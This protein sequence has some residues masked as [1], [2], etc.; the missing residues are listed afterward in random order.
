MY[1]CK[2]WKYDGRGGVVVEDEEMRVEV[3]IY[4]L[5]VGRDRNKKIVKKT[6]LLALTCKPRDLN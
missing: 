3:F 5:C 1:D 2:K 6:I 4:V